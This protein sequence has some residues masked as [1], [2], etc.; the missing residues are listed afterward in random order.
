MQRRGC[1]SSLQ[2]FCGI[3][4]NNIQHNANMEGCF[5]SMQDDHYGKFGPIFFFFLPLSPHPPWCLSCSGARECVW[6]SETAFPPPPSR[7]L[8]GPFEHDE[9]GE[10]GEVIEGE[11]MHTYYFPAVEIRHEISCQEKPQCIVL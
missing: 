10:V 3:E 9:K 8:T 1:R 6:D 2:S 11:R 5:F 4:V 7:T